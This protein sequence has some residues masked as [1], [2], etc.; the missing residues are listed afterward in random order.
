MDVVDQLLSVQ[1]K[2]VEIRQMEKEQ[3]DIPARK[4][5]EEERLS[6]HKAQIDAARNLLKQKQA[7]VD[8]LELQSNSCREQIQKLKK[9]QLD[10][11]TNKE[12][13]A[14]SAEIQGQE[15]RISDIEDR[16]LVAMED[17]EKA[18]TEIQNRKSALSEEEAVLAE[19]LKELDSRAAEIETRL[20]SARQEREELAR[21]IDRDWLQQYESIMR[22][23]DRALV[24]LKDR[25]CGGCHMK[26]P[27]YIRH[28]AKKRQGMVACD[29]CGRLLY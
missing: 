19:D 8:D 25:V 4:Q 7:V 6:E 24:L 26:L 23:K 13:R 12:Y 3:K 28:D 1:E 14:M 10:I 15:D 27:T 21:D 17:V 16:Q 2:D 20:Q 9:Q 22:S 11:K 18:K 5:A 29:F